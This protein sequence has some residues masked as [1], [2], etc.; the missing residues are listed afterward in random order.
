MVGSILRNSTCAIWVKHTPRDKQARIPRR[1]RQDF[2]HSHLGRIRIHPHAQGILV[3]PLPHEHAQHASGN[4]RPQVFFK[5]MIV[6]EENQH[7]Y[8]IS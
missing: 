5:L 1:D 6:T 3:T 8:K 2:T 4:C 7:N